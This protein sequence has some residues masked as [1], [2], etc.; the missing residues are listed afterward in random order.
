MFF[1]SQSL[2]LPKPLTFFFFFFHI[3][4][5][6]FVLSIS[7]NSNLF[8]NYK[9]YLSNFHL[10]LISTN[11][12]FSLSIHS[13]LGE[14]FSQFKDFLSNFQVIF[15]LSLN[16]NLIFLCLIAQSSSSIV[17][18]VFFFFKNQ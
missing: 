5:S 4:L 15:W 14:T 6:L 1:S 17:V 13:L 18:Y 9:T 10:T 2:S 11:S 12:K 7:Q 8:T 3:S 16:F